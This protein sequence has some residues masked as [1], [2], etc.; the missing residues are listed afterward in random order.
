MTIELIGGPNDGLI[1]E[2]PSCMAPC[3][4]LPTDINVIRAVYQSACRCG[5]HR[6]EDGKLRYYFCGYDVG[7]DTCSHEEDSRP[8][9]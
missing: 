4:T 3:L 9:T 6:I 7:A 1:L 2:A 8:H 5:C